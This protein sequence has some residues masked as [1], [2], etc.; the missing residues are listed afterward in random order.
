MTNIALQFS[1]LARQQPQALAVIEQKNDSRYTYQQ[2]DQISDIIAQ[3]LMARDIGAG[4]RIVLMVQP[5]LDFF[6]LVFA[7]LKIGAV[8]VAID[9]GIGIKRLGNCIAESKPDVFI[10]N[11]K[12]HLARHLFGWGKSTITT[13]LVVGN[14]YIPNCLYGE[15]SLAAIKRAGLARQQKIVVSTQATDLAAILFT[16]GSTGSP[17][18]VIYTHAN[19]TAQIQAL[20]ALYQPKPDLRDLSTFPLFALFATVMGI[21]AVVPDMNFSHPATVKPEKI[22]SAIN[23]HQVTNMF[24]SPALLWRLGSYAQQRPMAL[25]SLRRVLSAGAPVSSKIIK[26][27]ATMLSTS[28]QILTPYGA[29]ECL[30]ISVIGSDELLTS[31]AQQTAQGYGVCVGRAIGETTIKIIAISEQPIP[32]WHEQLTLKSG[33]I[34]EIVVKGAQASRAYYGRP[35]QTQFAKIMDLADSFYH[36]TGDAGYLDQQQRLWFCGRL[37]NRLTID[38]QILF[39]TPCEEIFNTHPKVL[40]SALIGL[41]P[42]NKAVLCVELQPPFRYTDKQQIMDELLAIGAQFKQSSMIQQI[43]FHPAFP[44]DIRHNAK[45]NYAKLTTWVAKRAA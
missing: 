38:D 16:S 28:A 44:V 17:K 27:F 7:L 8:I 43:L 15:Y 12:A 30:P 10:G 41:K 29:T 33:E 21:T 11:N 14:D 1:E 20:R 18:G 45:I 25:P 42:A 35:Q 5:G 6:A 19:L 9:A 37:V 31:T 22:F 36:R 3:G 34:G 13:N 2:L 39:T 4:V 23:D 26:C 24:G 40:R 32:Q